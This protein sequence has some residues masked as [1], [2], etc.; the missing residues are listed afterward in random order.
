MNYRSH[1]IVEYYANWLLKIYWI[2]APFM[3]LSCLDVFPP[4]NSGEFNYIW[5]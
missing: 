2:L 4:S 1:P 3:V 5:G